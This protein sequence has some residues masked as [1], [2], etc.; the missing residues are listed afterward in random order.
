MESFYGG[1]PGFSFILKGPYV[2]LNDIYEALDAGS[3][4]YGEYAL[5][6][7][8]NKTGS[9]HGNIYR[10][11]S[12]QGALE[13]VGNVTTPAPL[14]ELEFNNETTGDGDIIWTPVPGYDNGTYNDNIKGIVS[15]DTENERIGLGFSFPYS[16][17]D[18]SLNKTSLEPSITPTFDSTHPF[19]HRYDLSIPY[20]NVA[21]E[22]AQNEP[23]LSAG[24]VWL[25]LEDGDDSE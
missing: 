13:Y 14:Y 2:D 25:V 1:R 22:D 16:V 24:G 9:L 23:E 11:A 7:T 3:L 18:V 17:V 21:V 20:G 8:E 5:I 4:K 19:Y 6:S 15:Y 12:I 10:V